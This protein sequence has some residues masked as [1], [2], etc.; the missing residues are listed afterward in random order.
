MKPAKPTLQAQRRDRGFVSKN[1]A[2]EMGK[3]ISA[4]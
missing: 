2:R 4:P 1:D 3:N